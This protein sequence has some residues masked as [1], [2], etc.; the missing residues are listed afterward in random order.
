M[1]VIERNGKAW[2]RQWLWEIRPTQK[3]KKKRIIIETM[4]V[5]DT[6]KKKRKRKPERS[7]AKNLFLVVRWY[8][9]FLFKSQQ[10]VCYCWNVWSMPHAHTH[11]H[12]R[13]K[14]NQNQV[15]IAQ[16][17]KSELIFIAKLIGTNDARVAWSF[18]FFEY[19]QTNECEVSGF[20]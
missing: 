20:S 10:K 1:H 9:S 14:K 2:R 15:A 19:F 18:V 5:V 6:T 17:L 8:L 13:K 16:I 7:L 3:R 4:I 11:T 12:T